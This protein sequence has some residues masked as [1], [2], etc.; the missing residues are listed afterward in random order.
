VVSA[1]KAWGPTQ[2]SSTI[3]NVRTAVLNVKLLK[4]GIRTGLLL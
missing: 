4:N 1:E 3:R 2:N